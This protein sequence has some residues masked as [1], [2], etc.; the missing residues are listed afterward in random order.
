MAPKARSKA[1]ERRLPG[2]VSRTLVLAEPF[3]PPGMNIPL[4]DPFES[5]QFPEVIEDVLEECGASICAFNRR[6]TLLAVGCFN[7]DL[8]IWD[9][10]TRGVAAVMPA[11]AHKLTSICW[12]RNGTR[13]LTSSSDKCAARG[14]APRSLRLPHPHPLAVREGRRPCGPRARGAARAAG[15]RKSRA[16]AP[17]ATAHPP[18]VATV[19]R[20]V[21]LLP[22][23]LRRMEP[24]ASRGQGP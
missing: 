20:H 7:G 4:L 9:F 18:P 14:P 2:G 10:V 13:L 3:A 5:Q 15:A 16:P 12:A 22:L 6:G 19:A 1:P 21:A 17:A 11:H 23:W 24:C 8:Q